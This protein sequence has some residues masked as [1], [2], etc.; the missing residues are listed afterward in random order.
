MRR[1]VLFKIPIFT[2]TRL[3]HSGLSNSSSSFTAHDFYL[4]M[5]ICLLNFPVHQFY[6]RAECILG[7]HGFTWFTRNLLVI[8]TKGNLK[9]HIDKIPFAHEKLAALC[10]SGRVLGTGDCI[11]GTEIVYWVPQVYSEHWSSQFVVRSIWSKPHA[12]QQQGSWW[13]FYK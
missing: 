5:I 2:R 1:R 3:G 6:S 7:T 8:H 11:L 4:T 9:W 10:H 13:E 12:S